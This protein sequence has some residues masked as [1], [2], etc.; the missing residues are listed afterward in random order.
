M[1]GFAP[2]IPVFAPFSHIAVHIAK[3]PASWEFLATGCC[4]FGR[5]LNI[6]FQQPL[7]I[8]EQRIVIATGIVGRCAGS[9]R[10]FPF[11]LRWETISICILIQV[12]HV[13]F[14]FVH[15]FLFTSRLVTRQEA[16]LLTE[17]VTK[18]HGV[19]PVDPLNGM[20]LG[21]TRFGT[22]AWP[23]LRL[24]IIR[25]G[26]MSSRAR[27]CCSMS[28]RQASRSVGMCDASC[29]FLVRRDR[30]LVRDIL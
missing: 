6:V 13:K 25:T 19:I 10:E 16:L 8:P 1:F 24:A 26:S 30:K 27:A 20:S 23:V 14:L 4:Q 3:P 11:D 9:A 18:R 21:R 22:N 12:P 15:K 17:P 7:I 29:M 28:V 2:A 5:K